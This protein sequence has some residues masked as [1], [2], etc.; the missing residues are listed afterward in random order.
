MASQINVSSQGAERFLILSSIF[1]LSIIFCFSCHTD[2]KSSLN[3][4]DPKIGGV[5]L[6]LQPTRPTVQIPNQII[7]VYPV[8]EDYFDDQIRYFPLTIISHRNGEL[9]GIM[10]FTGKELTAIPVSTWDQNLEVST[11]YYLSEWLDL[12]VAGTA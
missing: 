1:L 2:Q 5:G 7:R 3:Y 10:P 9:F 11:P 4:V 12:F 6:L 8:R